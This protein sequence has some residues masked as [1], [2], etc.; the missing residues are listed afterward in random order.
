[1]KHTIDMQKFKVRTDLIMETLDGSIISKESTYKNIK[2]TETNIDEKQASQIG[3]KERTYFTITFEDITDFHNEQD[4]TEVFSKTLNQLLQLENI[5][6]LD[7]GLIIGLGNRKSTPDALGPLAIDK[8]LVTEHLFLYGDVEE[9]FRPTI[10]C[11]PGVMAQT[12]METSQYIKALVD[13]FQPN[14]V[15][16][17][18]ALASQS[19][20]R[21]HTTIQM[22][23]TGISPGSG[24]GNKRKEISKKVLKIP[25]FAIGV[26]TVVDAVTI[27]SDTISYLQ[28][29]YAFHKS[30]MK[31]P[32]SKMV[33]SRQM[34]YS[35]KN[36][37]LDPKEKE[38]LFGILGQLQE[39]E[40]KELF[41]EV[42][43]PIGYNYMVTTKEMD[44]L[45]DKLANILANGINQAL[46]EKV[47]KKN[48]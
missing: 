36:M 8:I 2:V 40:I 22:S 15:I 4:V 20:D 10:A 12:G 16:V 35:K 17:I 9:G 31:N 18:D 28:K 45:I 27:V 43:T 39:Q 47:N 1:M 11:A 46:H 3:K 24:I 32:M 34:D 7:K 38:N 6:K 44:F 14:F 29:F 21:V 42:L 5:Q 30:F 25:V 37:Q 13:T 19:L 48:T 23:N 33:L 26:P 41:E